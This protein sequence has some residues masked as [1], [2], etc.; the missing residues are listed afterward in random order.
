MSTPITSQISND[1]LIASIVTTP[2]ENLQR[3]GE[4]ECIKSIPTDPLRD[5]L[6]RE[7]TKQAHDALTHPRFSDLTFPRTRKQR[8]D[9]D[10]PGQRFAL[11]SFIPSSGASPD[12]DGCFGVAK[13]RGSFASVEEADEHAQN[14]VRNFDSYCPIDFVLV[15]RDFPIMKDNSVYVSETREVDIRNVLDKTTKEFIEKKRQ[16]EKKEIEEIQERQ[17]KLAEAPANAENPDDIDYYIQLRVKKA[18][19]LMRQD[20]AAKVMTQCKKVN[21]KTNAVLTE[22]EDKHPEFAEQY[23]ER[24]ENALK[25]SGADVA[26]NPLIKYMK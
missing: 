24:Y 5:P 10:V 13:V 3:K 15:G 16:E 11:I 2:Q 1:Q 21:E 25:E 19:A 22:I 26:Q 23:L 7:E 18:T 12:K 8:A 20:E 9:P 4:P 17:K 6:S 14:I